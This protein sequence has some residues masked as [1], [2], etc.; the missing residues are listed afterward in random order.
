MIVSWRYICTR[1]PCRFPLFSAIV[2]MKV[3]KMIVVNVG[4]GIKMAFHLRFH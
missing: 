1:T 3:E 2:L 4:N